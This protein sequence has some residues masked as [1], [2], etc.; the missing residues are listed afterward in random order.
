MGLPIYDPSNCIDT[1]MH[2][3]S[4]EELENYVQHSKSPIL[5]IRKN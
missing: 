2:D 4:K 5:M 1:H 3:C